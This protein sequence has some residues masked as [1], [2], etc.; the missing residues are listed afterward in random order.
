M[1][2]SV[3]KVDNELFSFIFFLFSIKIKKLLSFANTQIC[4]HPY[5]F[6]Y[7]NL[8]LMLH[9]INHYYGTKPIYSIINYVTL[10]NWSFFFFFNQNFHIVWSSS[11]I[12]SQNKEVMTIFCCFETQLSNLPAMLEKFLLGQIFYVHRNYVFK[13]M[14]NEFVKKIQKHFYLK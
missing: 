14:S 13:R 2:V 4:H 7:V 11:L 10:T 5:S 8:A 9:G 1:Y 3:K 6:G 12:I